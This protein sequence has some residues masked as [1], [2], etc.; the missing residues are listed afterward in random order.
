MS[1]LSPFYSCAKRALD[2]GMALAGLAVLSPVWVVIWLAIM[3]E[4]GSPV[5][6]KQNR[7]GRHGRTFNAF[8]FRTMYVATLYAPVNHQAREDD[9]RVTRVGRIL[10][11]TAIDESPQLINILRG[12][13]SFVGPRPLLAAE[14]EIHDPVE[15]DIQ[16]V[17]GYKERVSVVPGLT[18]IAQFH[19]SRD[20][21][22][23]EKF[24]YDLEYIRNRCLARDIKLILL[25][26]CVTFL[27]RWEKRGVKLAN[28]QRPSCGN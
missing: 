6:F 26:L 20:V 27:G 3:I 19:A 28:G 10:R 25:S 13:M 9:P 16:A 22:R 7:I 12:E 5:F 15:C 24:E 4:D 11:G 21:P 8:K 14:V 18:G 17:P 2:I 23:D 1:E